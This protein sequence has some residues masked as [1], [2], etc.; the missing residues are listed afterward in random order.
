MI[1]HLQDSTLL[2]KNRL[3]NIWKIWANGLDIATGQSSTQKEARSMFTMRYQLVLDWYLQTKRGNRNMV[4]GNFAM[5]NV[6]T[7]TDS[8]AEELSLAT[9]SQRKC[10]AS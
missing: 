9:Y 5:K 3:S 7:Q 6:R 4:L 1:V 8:T 2:K 10:E